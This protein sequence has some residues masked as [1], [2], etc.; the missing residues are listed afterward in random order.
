[1]VKLNMMGQAAGILAIAL[2]F[3]TAA[4]AQQPGRIRGQIEKIDGAALVLKVRDGSMLNVKLADDA[5]VSALEK[6]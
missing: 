5:R 1:M 3:A 4:Q 6:A 2:L